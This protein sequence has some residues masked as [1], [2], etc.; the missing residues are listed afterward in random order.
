MA[1]QFIFFYQIGRFSSIFH[2]YGLMIFIQQKIS[3]SADQPIIKIRKLDFSITKTRRDQFKAAVFNQERLL[4]CTQSLYCLTRLPFVFQLRD[5]YNDC[6]YVAIR[7]FIQYPKH[8]FHYK[9]TTWLVCLPICM[10]AQG[11]L[12]KWTEHSQDLHLLKIHSR[13]GSYYT[14]GLDG[15]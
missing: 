4:Y 5:V 3:F 14:L 7:R 1:Y 15:G 2:L 6:T 9:R 11:P 10:L 8:L 13:G 12:K